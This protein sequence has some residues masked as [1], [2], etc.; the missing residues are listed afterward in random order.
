MKIPCRHCGVN[1]EH[2]EWMSGTEVKCPACGQKTL[3][4]PSLAQ[5]ASEIQ[6]ESKISRERE[7][8]R[9]VAR[10]FKTAAINMC[11]LA[12]IAIVFGILLLITGSEENYHAE[13]GIGLFSVA[14]AFLGIAGWLYLICQI[15]HI[16]ANTHRD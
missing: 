7:I 3:L 5:E 1:I 11:I 14:G 2:E 4:A 10:K 9:I 15:I 16:R 12:A 8:I 13:L 6:K